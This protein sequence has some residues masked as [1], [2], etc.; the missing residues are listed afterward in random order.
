MSNG[1]KDPRCVEIGAR[2]KQARLEMDG[3]TQRQLGELLGVTDR[4]VLMY[5]KGEARPYRHLQR[6][7]EVLGRPRE[8]FL[9]SA[10]GQVG[11]GDVDRRLSTLEAHIGTLLEA[12][13][14]DSNSPNGIATNVAARL[15]AL[16]RC[17]ADARQLLALSEWDDVSDI[18]IEIET[19]AR[20]AYRELEAAT[21]HAGVST[22]EAAA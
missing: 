7:V 11:H 1:A 6:L 4:S 18:L 9:H 16:E 10:E 15:D 13:A 22:R 2:I 20:Y 12:T 8:W 21:A 3:M 14:R 5:E 17:L 19:E